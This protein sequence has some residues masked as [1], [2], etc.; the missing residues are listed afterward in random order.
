ML[1]THTH[2]HWLLTHSFT[3]EIPFSKIMEVIVNTFLISLENVPNF[4][5]ALVSITA[6]SARA[7]EWI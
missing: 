4:T 1:Y 7:K 5:S 3:L 2:I 6:Q